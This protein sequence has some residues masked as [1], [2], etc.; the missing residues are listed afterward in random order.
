MRVLYDCVT[1]SSNII[2]ISNFDKNIDEIL[3]LSSLS[4]I[5]R[6]EAADSIRRRIAKIV[7]K[8]SL[9]YQH[10]VLVWHLQAQIV[11]KAFPRVLLPRCCG[12]KDY[13]LL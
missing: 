7:L 3:S 6:R 4:V 10:L 12:A 11:Q 5:E 2:V 1:V 13:I 9:M 8:D